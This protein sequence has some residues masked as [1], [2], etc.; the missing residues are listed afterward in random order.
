MQSPEHRSR[1][2]AN[3]ALGD[4]LRWAFELETSPAQFGAMWLTRE[5]IPDAKDPFDAILAPTTT[6]DGLRELK[7]AYKMLR[8]SSATAA[9]RSLA[10]RLYA[11]TIA[12][13][14]VRY[15]TSI[16]TQSVANLQRA[17]TDLAEDPSMPEDLR[18]VAALALTSQPPAAP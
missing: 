5:I 14:L 7:N 11:A 13:A 12:A 1:P 16:S 6:L 15:K 17:F 10:A 3:S 18:A 4:T 8:T 9:E 2:D